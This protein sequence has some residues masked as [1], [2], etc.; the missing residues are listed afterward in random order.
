MDK[1]KL[2]KEV[3]LLVGNSDNEKALDLLINT[4]EQDKA[5]QDLADYAIHIKGTLESLKKRD[6]NNTI[7]SEETSIRISKI[8]FQ[9]FDLLERLEN[10]DLEWQAP[11]D[12]EENTTKSTKLLLISFIIGLLLLGVSFLVYSTIFNES[13]PP[14]VATDEPVSTSPCPDFKQNDPNAFNILLFPF[15]SFN[16]QMASTHKAISIRLAELAEKYDI[17]LGVDFYNKGEIMDSD[18]PKN[19][20][21]ATKKAKDCAANLVIWG[22]EEDK[23]DK[24]IIRTKYKF[25]N[26]ISLSAIKLTEDTEIDTVEAFSNIINGQE[27][28]TENIENNIKLIFGILAKEQQKDAIAIEILEDI[29]SLDST[30]SF[31]KEMLKADIY[32][33]NEKTEKAYESYTKVLETHPDYWLARKNRGMLNYK[34]AEYEASIEDLTAELAKR[35]TDTASL[36][37]RGSAYTKTEQIRKAQKDLNTAK[38]LD[39][40]NSTIKQ[41]FYELEE[42]QKMINIRKIELNEKV[43]NNPSDVQ[44]TANLAQTYQHIGDYKAAERFATMAIKID[45][46][47]VQSYVTKIEA[48]IEQGKE[49]EAKAAYEEALKKNI[50]GVKL[51]EAS[52][53]IRKLVQP[54]SNTV[55]RRIN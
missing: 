32:L 23:A 55:R 40:K 33:N 25:L 31:I 28:I 14:V 8:R 45:P 43:K 1:M 52:P 16:S 41:K 35:P 36:I 7:T 29:E 21:E 46:N 15:L 27:L 30:S 4:L 42:T 18:Y 22:T 39:P 5:Y 49:K 9:I 48:F 20:N 11:K 13:D 26:A 38:E 17:S 10:N 50:D 37:V 44:A 47:N 6:L 19:S 12:N 53:A 54:V 2:I 34:K 3:K 51:L 24:T